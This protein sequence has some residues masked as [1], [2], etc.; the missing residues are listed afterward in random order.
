MTS[1]DQLDQL[2]QDLIR[3]EGT[4]LIAYDDATGLSIRPGVILKGHPTIGHGR[5]L[6]TNG[7]TE[8]EALY[9]LTNDINR[10][11]A[12][13]SKYPWFVSLDYTR[14]NAIL[15]MAF[16]LGVTGLLEFQ[17]M[18]QHLSNHPPQ[19]DLAAQDMEDSVWYKEAGM[20]GMRLASAIRDGDILE[21][22]GSLVQP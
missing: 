13:L 20:R 22:Y 9:L 5:S 8:E 11:T 6:D 1:K 14:Q 16:N 12:I 7:I 21:Y 2:T 17:N 3:D 18:I 10:I 19:Y 15:N 4:R